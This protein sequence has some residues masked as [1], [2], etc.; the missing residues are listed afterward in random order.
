MSRQEQQESEES[1]DSYKRIVI[2][3]DRFDRSIRETISVEKYEQEI[4]QERNER[5]PT[6]VKLIKQLIT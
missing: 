2:Y 5:E 3:E 1:L 6:S 4:N